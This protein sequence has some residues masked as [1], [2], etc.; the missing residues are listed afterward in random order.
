MS[1]PAV[2]CVSGT[3]TGV[4]K[5]V[6]TAALAAAAGGRVTVVKPV[7]T[8]VLPDEP[9]DVDD[10]L[11]LAPDVVG[12]ELHRFP[13]PLAP[14]AAARRSGRA[15]VRVAD[16]VAQISGVDAD[17]VLVEGA[18]GLLVRFGDEP[19]ETF[20]DL[21]LALAAPV[22]VVTTAG[23]G[24]LNH[25]A[26]TL[27]ALAS[28]S[29]PLAGLVIGAWPADPDLACRANLV[30]LQRLAPLAGVLPADIGRSSARAFRDAATGGVSPRW[31][32]TFDA[33]D[34]VT[35]NS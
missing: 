3:G 13:D 30:D 32:G 27:E 20:A 14:A 26:L 33:A 16:L 8:G 7:Q 4:G 23:L 25:T 5:T 15:P 12:R 24:T 19:A 18:G 6:V 28:R 22:L 11:R 1:R 35:R 10:V 17:L 31:G 29:I 21:A 34:F 2:V 9:G